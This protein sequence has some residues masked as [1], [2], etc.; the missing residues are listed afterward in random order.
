MHGITTRVER[1]ADFAEP[2][3]V[4]SDLH[5]GHRVSRIRSVESLRPLVAGAG[6]MVFNG[7]TWQELAPDIRRHSSEMLEELRCLCA[8]EGCESVFL[9]GNHDPGW[10]GEGWVSLAE[11]R[12]VITHGDALFREGA[13]W[14]REL[15][16]Q[17]GK[18]RAMWDAHPLAEED[19]GE[20]LKLAREIARG[21]A[22]RRHPE[23]RAVWQRAWDAVVPPQ[24]ALKIVE[25][26]LTQADAGG[27]FCECYFPEAEVLVIGHFHY[28]GSWLAGKRRVIN[29]GSFVV[30]GRAHWVEWHD[31]WLSRGVVDESGKDAVGIGKILDRWRI[32]A[33]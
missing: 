25:A 33:F 9:P 17:P 22:T 2:V 8:E 14:K 6:T 4:V 32:R 31:G 12:V 26:W 16:T 11:G 28:A 23:G 27:K 10:G 30:P 24:R 7:D 19:A 21:F 20:R 1:G 18:V 3:R 5:L 13:P 29:T 15:L